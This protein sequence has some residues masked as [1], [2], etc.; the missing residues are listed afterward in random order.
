M[1]SKAQE[2]RKQE[3]EIASLKQGAELQAA[4][5]RKLR[6]E[7]QLVKLAKPGDLD[8]AIAE[9]VGRTEYLY[10]VANSEGPSSGRPTRIVQNAN[11]PF[12]SMAL[13]FSGTVSLLLLL[14]YIIWKVG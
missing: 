12:W 10:R 2:I 6:A 4:E 13:V 5:I 11:F 1:W 3:L 7:N 9:V 8:R 14:L